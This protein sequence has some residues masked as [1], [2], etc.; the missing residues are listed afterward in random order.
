MLLHLLTSVGFITVIASHS[1]YF[2]QSIYKHQRHNYPLPLIKLSFRIIPLDT[3]YPQPFIKTLKLT[4]NISFS[5]FPTTHV[6]IISFIL[7]LLIN[8]PHKI[9]EYRT[10][11]F[12]TYPL[13]TSAHHILYIFRLLPLYLLCYYTLSLSQ[14]LSIL[15]PSCI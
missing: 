1:I 2:L 9:F 6:S 14:I 3:A 5:H 10:T 13:A 7:L 11:S 8:P 15:L 12:T 4:I